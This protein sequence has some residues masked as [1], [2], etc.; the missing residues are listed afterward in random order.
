MY[1]VEINVNKPDKK[2]NH[3]VS[4]IPNFE[5]SNVAATNT[6]CPWY[7]QTKKIYT[8]FIGSSGLFY[9]MFAHNS[10]VLMN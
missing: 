1:Y 10:V 3:R 5:C 9:I 8:E 7:N 4:M 6:A 2:S